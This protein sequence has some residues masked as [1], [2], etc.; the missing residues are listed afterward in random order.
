MSTHAA[1]CGTS[2][3]SPW[4]GL[5]GPGPSESG[6]SRSGLFQVGE[7]E[8]EIRFLETAVDLHH[9]AG[10]EAAG[11]RREPECAARNVGGFAEPLQRRAA[12]H[13][14]VHFGVLEHDLERAR[15]DRTDGD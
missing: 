1:Q 2:A 14:V 5:W 3:F 13:L 15:G 4:S 10:D 7:A 11:R 12:D 9:L 8:F 6:Y